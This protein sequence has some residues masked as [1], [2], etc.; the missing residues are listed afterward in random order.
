MNYEV[1]LRLAT[2]R[3]LELRG[4]IWL[5]TAYVPGTRFFSTLCPVPGWVDGGDQEG[6]RGKVAQPE[7]HTARGPRVRPKHGSV[8]PA[9][10]FSLP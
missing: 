3:Y 1:Y 4:V 5:R 8:V 2:K 10:V 9:C 6:T 7:T